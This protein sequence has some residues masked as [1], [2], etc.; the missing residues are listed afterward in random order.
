MKYRADP[1][2]KPARFSLSL[3]STVPILRKRLN[4]YLQTLTAGFGKSKLVQLRPPLEKPT[5]ICAASKNILLCAYDAER[6][7]IQVTLHY[8]G[9]AGT[10]VK[11]VTYPAGISKVIS[12]KFSHKAQ[13]AYFAVVGVDSGFYN[14]SFVYLYCFDGVLKGL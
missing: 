7:I 13:R 8:N 11:F 9:I 1:L 3:D 5:S 12:W 4:T 2:S 6:G 14:L 10:G